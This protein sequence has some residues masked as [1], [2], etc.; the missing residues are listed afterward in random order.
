LLPHAKVT[1]VRDL[2]TAGWRVLLV[3]DGV[4]RDLRFPSRAIHSPDENGDLH[5]G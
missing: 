5:H 2:E 3:G 1:A 4:H